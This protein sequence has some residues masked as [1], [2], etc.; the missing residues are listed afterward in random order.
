[1]IELDNVLCNN[2]KAAASAVTTFFFFGVF[3]ILG[4]SGMYLKV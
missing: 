2:C 3:E 4:Y 1:M